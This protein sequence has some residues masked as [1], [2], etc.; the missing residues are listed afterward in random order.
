MREW[1]ET[2]S[3]SIPVFC[4]YQKHD[5]LDSITTYGRPFNKPS[6]LLFLLGKRCLLSLL[7]SVNSLG[8]ANAECLAVFI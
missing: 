5:W 1:L 7:C 6:C 8:S 2:F 3:D 4:S